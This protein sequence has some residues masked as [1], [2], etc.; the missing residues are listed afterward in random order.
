[1][2]DTV[3]NHRILLYSSDNAGVGHSSIAIALL[4]GLRGVSPDCEVLV[5]SSTGVPQ[6]FL[7]RGIEIVKIPSLA[8]APKQSENALPYQPR[9]LQKTSLQ[10]GMHLRQQIIDSVFNSY[11]PT[12]LLIDHHVTGID[13]EL[14][15][16]LLKKQRGFC[17]FTCAFL[18]RGII[19]SPEVIVPPFERPNRGIK[20]IPL[21]DAFDHFLIFEDS[22]TLDESSFNLLQF[23]HLRHKT[24]CVGKLAVKQLDEMLSRAELWERLELPEKKLILMNV[25]HGQASQ[26]I[27]AAAVGAFQRQ[28]LHLTHTLLATTTPYMETEELQRLQHEYRSEG[29]RIRGFF[30]EFPDAMAHA[31]LA[32]CRSG[33]NTIS[34]LFLTG[35]SAVVIPEDYSSGEQTIRAQK[36][37]NEGFRVI[38]PEDVNTDVMSDAF[39]SL[40]NS[41]KRSCADL[42]SKR[43]AREVMSILTNDVVAISNAE[44]M[45][46]TSTPRTIN[47]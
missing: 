12:I 32:I 20:N 40:L 31:D 23:A 45:G 43:V 47:G 11:N 9:Y 7:S 44:S 27:L 10:Q 22:D 41:A 8:P 42:D 4:N 35:C 17:N 6:R 21:A 29:V 26:E 1:M 5:I 18:C 39:D 14:T 38:N 19:S 15:S 46:S 3:T 30:D 34:E 13:G 24:R 25:G 33:Y 16:W 28:N 37:P 36:L 2:R